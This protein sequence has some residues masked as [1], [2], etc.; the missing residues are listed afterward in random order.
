[1]SNPPLFQSSDESSGP[2]S[3]QMATGLS[4]VTTQWVFRRFLKADAPQDFTLAIQLRLAVFVE[5]RAI[6]E[7]L[8]QDEFDEEAVHWLLLHPESGLPVATGRMISYQE[9][10]QSRPVAKLGRI[11]V[12]QSHR[13]QRIGEKLMAD[14]LV[15]AKSEG[16]EQVILDADTRVL[17]FYERLGFVREGFE[18]VEANTSLYR[19]RLVF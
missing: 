13:G 7:D 9:A 16:F 2:V 15:F 4:G 10:C 5:E 3:G 14:I 18:F 12:S 8:E 6:P 17:P 11:A 1:M 19:M